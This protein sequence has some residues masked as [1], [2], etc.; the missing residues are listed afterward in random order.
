VQNFAADHHLDRMGIVS[1]S[2]FLRMLASLSP[3]CLLDHVHLH[4][5]FI[6]KDDN[7]GE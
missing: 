7:K 2:F 1:E 6:G 5:R 3:Y 4:H